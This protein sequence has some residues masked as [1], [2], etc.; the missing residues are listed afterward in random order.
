MS[1]KDLA[2]P[3]SWISE[4]GDY[5][6]ELDVVRLRNRAAAE[7]EQKEFWEI[8]YTCMS[9]LP[10]SMGQAF[11]LRELKGWTPEKICKELK[12]KPNT[13]WVVLHRV[14]TQLKS[15][16]EANWTRT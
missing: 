9:K 16:L 7:D 11:T 5:L 6:F 4:H 14:S 10:D 12:L 13:L 2:N 1:N 8:F 15:C 3:E